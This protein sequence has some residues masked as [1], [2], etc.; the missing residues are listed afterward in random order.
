MN[1]IEPDPNARAGE[2]TRH[3]EEVLLELV[4]RYG[5]SQWEKIAGKMRKGFTGAACRAR[6]P[7]MRTSVIKVRNKLSKCGCREGVPACTAHSPAPTVDSVARYD[8]RPCRGRGQRRR[9]TFSAKWSP[10]TAPSGGPS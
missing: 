2:W 10:S 3:D 1:S 7:Q 4:S 8:P 5:E 9:T 6:W